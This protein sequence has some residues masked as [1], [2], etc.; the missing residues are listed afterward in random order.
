M[1]EM[2]AGGLARSPDSCAPSARIARSTRGL[3]FYATPHAGS[4]LADW[5]WNLRFPSARPS[6]VHACHIGWGPSTHAC[7]ARRHRCD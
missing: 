4:W 6:H 7:A 2:L 1:K 5:G 3:V